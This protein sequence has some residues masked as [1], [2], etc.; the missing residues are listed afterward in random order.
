M[1]SRGR[2]WCC[3][4]QTPPQTRNTPRKV[5]LDISVSA[6]EQASTLGYG[7]SPVGSTQR[8]FEVTSVVFAMLGH[9]EPGESGVGAAFQGDGMPRTLS[10]LS[11]S[12]AGEDTSAIDRDVLIASG[13]GRIDEPLQGGVEAGESRDVQMLARIRS[14]ESTQVTRVHF[15]GRR[16]LAAGWGE[17][18]CK[19]PQQQGHRNHILTIVLEDVAE[20]AAVPRAK[21]V[22]VAIRSHRARQVMFPTNATDGSLDRRQ[23]RIRQA[24]LPERSGQRQQIQMSCARRWV[25]AV[26]PMT[27]DDER[28]VERAAVVCDQ[29]GIRRDELP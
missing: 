29:T 4:R 3:T 24:M 8:R 5:S 6:T 27:C 7:P 28:P 2:Q 20:I 14:T 21:V 16:A 17:I 1:S 11:T 9:V 18:T 19:Y 26:E 15:C 13:L 25:V 23:A 22:Q 12:K 10:L